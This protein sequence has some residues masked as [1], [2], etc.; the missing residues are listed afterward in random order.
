LTAFFSDAVPT[1]FFGVAG[2]MDSPSDGNNCIMLEVSTAS[3]SGETR[4]LV[5]FLLTDDSPAMYRA[6]SEGMRL[7]RDP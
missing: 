6:F 3:F 2:Q 5:A 7:N 4:E 1:F